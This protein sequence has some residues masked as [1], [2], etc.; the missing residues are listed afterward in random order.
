M[1]ETTTQSTAHWNGTTQ[2]DRMLK[3]L[4]PEFVKI[5]ERKPSDW[6]AFS[7]KYAEL[8]NYYAPDNSIDGDWSRFFGNDISVFISSIIATDLKKIEREHNRLINELENAPRLE[9]KAESLQSL[10]E[11]VLQ[12]T[13]Q[14]NDWYK[15]ALHMNRLNPMDSSE[16][17]LELEN[18]IKQN[19]AQHLDSLFAYQKDLQFNIQGHLSEESIRE[20]F[21]SNWF[22]KQELL[23]TRELSVDDPL[24]E[25]KVKNYTKRIRLLYRAFYSVTAYILQ[26]SPRVLKQTFEDK[27]DHRPDVALFIA[28]VRLFKHAQ[29]QLNELTEKHLNFYYYDVLRQKERGFVSDQAHLY[30]TIGQHVDTYYLPEHTVLSAGRS[31]GGEQLFYKTDFGIELNQAKIESIRT[32]YVSKN[33]KIGIGSSYRLITNMYAAPVANSKDGFGERFLN[34]VEDWPTFG[35]ELLEKTESERQMGYAQLGW[36]VSAPVLEMEEGH[37]IVT[38]RFEF[39]K[40]SMYTLNL[41]IKDISKNQNVSKE[42]AFSKIFRNS[43][44]VFFTTPEGWTQASTCEILPPDDWDK[45]EITIVASFAVSAPSIVPYNKEVIGENYNTPFPI[46]KVLHRNQDTIYSY[47][48]LKELMLERIFVDVSVKGIRRLALSSDLGSVDSSMPFQMFGSIPKVGSYLLIGKAELFKKELSD[49]QINIDWH[50]LPDHKKGLKGYYKEYGMGINNEAYKVRMSALSDGQFYPS[51]DSEPIEMQLF[52]PDTDAPDKPAKKTTWTGFDLKVL[53][54]KQDY[55]FELPAAFNNSVRSGY[56]KVELMSP[57]AAF[58]HE[59]YADI[60]TKVVTYNANPKKKGPDMPLPK[61]PFIP[62]AKSISLDYSASAQI[63]VISIGTLSKGN[64]AV[65]QLYHIHPYGV[66]RS[67]YQGRPMNRKLLPTYEDDA[68][69]FF[70]LSKLNP[71]STLS[72]YFEL[73]EQLDVFTIGKWEQKPELSW[74]YLCKDEW[75]DF[76]QTQ[77]LSDTTNGF[78]NTGIVM[79]DIPND[80]SLGNSILPGDLAW[81]RITLKGDPSRMARTLK[82]ATQALS[83]TWLNKN[84]NDEHLKAPLAANSIKRLEKPVSQIRA[85][86]QPFPSSGGRPGE[87]QQDFYVRTSER[88]RHKNRV[89]STWDYERIILERFPDIYQAKCVT[90]LNHEQFVPKGG[91]TVVVVPRITNQGEYFLPVVNPTILQSIKEVLEPLASPFANIKLRN[92]IYERVKISC[93]V[94]FTKGKNNG[95]FLKKLNEDIMAFMC[96]WMYGKGK[97][98]NLGGVLSKDV[99]LSFIEKRSYVDFVTK[100]S[101]VQVFHSEKG[102]DVDDTAIDTS[103]SPVIESTTPWSVLIPFETNP[104]Y[105]LDE[106]TFQTPEKASINSMILNGDFVMTEEKEGNLDD[107]F[108]AKKLGKKD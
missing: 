75:K 87:S 67:F 19:L 97:E 89:V 90:H 51:E 65:E 34:D 61:Q 93:G 14:I 7:A 46:V 13:S 91:V 39:E 108:K 88:L 47:S 77:V 9:D 42:D 35:E 69:L 57:Q 103:N 100:F 11:Q 17:E 68:Y 1:Q 20:R 8:I 31:E 95:T 60:Y 22:P 40:S 26:V 23:G 55:N 44:E 56:L 24:F 16:L 76:S 92:P 25:N 28:F 45:S 70:G 41:L 18:A 66:I 74:S 33:R 54:I 27:S 2:K 36:A 10:F 49:L 38:M 99:L 104:I 37:R 3:A 4:L 64:A 21:H 106:T 107:F 78:N 43:L 73:R 102:F 94:R 86:H 72:V 12:M 81:L 59:S 52:A 101:A 83:A 48:F 30:F 5:D 29:D 71:E 105:L 84:G 80:I 85:V 6:L 58:G 32:L 53:N 98:L 62:V 82:V 15:Q 79:L 63:N 96:P 50:N